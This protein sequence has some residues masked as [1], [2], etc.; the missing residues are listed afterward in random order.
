MTGQR[1]ETGRTREGTWKGHYTNM[2]E[3]NESSWKLTDK[4]GNFWESKKMELDPF[5]I[6]PT[7]LPHYFQGLDM[8]YLSYL[9]AVA[10]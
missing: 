3:K 1:E 4:R 8:W 2:Q 6:G 5:L 9:G 10:R 7:G